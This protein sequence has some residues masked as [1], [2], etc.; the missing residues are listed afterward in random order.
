[1]H[2][3][4]HTHTHTEQCARLRVLSAGAR[5]S[6]GDEVLQHAHRAVAL[7]LAANAGRQRSD[8]MDD[9]LGHDRVPDRGVEDGVVEDELAAKRHAGGRAGVQPARHA[10]LEEAADADVKRDAGRGE[11]RGEGDPERRWDVQEL[12]DV[13]AADREA[14]ARDLPRATR[15]E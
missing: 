13:P 5:S 11:R 12:G 14:E 9:A 4:M 6:V 2:M 3:H 1:M 15:R 8:V 7:L 10:A